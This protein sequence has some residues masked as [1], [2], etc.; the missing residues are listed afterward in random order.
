MIFIFYKGLEQ[1]RRG[2][3]KDGSVGKPLA[4]QA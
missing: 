2:R 4:I 3:R 1:K